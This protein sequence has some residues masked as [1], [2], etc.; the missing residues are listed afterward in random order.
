M[1]FGE[2]PDSLGGKSGGENLM[3]DALTSA[4]SLRELCLRH[5]GVVFKQGSVTKVAVLEIL[6]SP[7]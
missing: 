1:A 3:I 5:Y 7:H 4:K 2:G 6:R